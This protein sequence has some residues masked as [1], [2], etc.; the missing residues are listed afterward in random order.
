MI[1]K[2]T[3]DNFKAL[4][5]FDHYI[6]NLTIVTGLNSMGKSSFIQSLLLLRQTYEKNSFKAGLLLNG[7]Y[8]S[9]GNGKDALSMDAEE[10]FFRIG[11]EWEDDSELELIFDYKESSNLQPL[12]SVTPKDFSFSNSLFNANFKYIAAERVGPQ[13]T[14]PVSDFDINTLKSLGKNGAFTAHFLAE[15]GTKALAIPELSHPNSKTNN[16]SAETNAWMSEI[17]KGI[18]I[19]A[20]VIPEINLAS[21]QYSFETLSGEI[22]DKFRPENVGF[23][24]TYVLPVVVAVLSASPGDLII[25]ENPEAHLHPAG[26]SAIARLIALACENGVQVIAES[27]S[28]HFLNSIRVAA[29]RDLIS[30]E[31]VTIFF[32]STDREK[33][34]AIAV[35]E[36]FLKSDGSLDEWPEGFFDEWE[37]SLNKLIK[38]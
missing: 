30:S 9:I 38:D 7:E 16:L 17:S 5:S 14:Y 8:T 18:R 10:E 1:S 20:N 28:D 2:I 22:T 21:L 13:N 37:N 29:K 6:S 19:S 3:V 15:N 12:R 26:Q 34:H 4:N 33:D 31:N 32:F 35:T 36:P 23:G 11:I 24:L 25:I 27:H